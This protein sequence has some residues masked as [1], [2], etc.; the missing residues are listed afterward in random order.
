MHIVRISLLSFYKTELPFTP[1]YFHIAPFH[2]VWTVRF[3][4]LDINANGYML[5]NTWETSESHDWWFFSLAAGTCASRTSC[6]SSAIPSSASSLCVL[7]LFQVLHLL[8][9]PVNYAQ[10]CMRPLT[11]RN[12]IS[13]SIL[14][15]IIRSIYIHYISFTFHLARWMVWYGIALPHEWT[16]GRDLDPHGEQQF[17][18]WLAL[19]AG[20]DKGVQVWL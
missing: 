4:S 6:K 7:P 17:C 11:S 2:L 5:K 15:F 8:K 10:K 9:N 18:E 12:L 19:G 20:L 13:S 14:H 3:F 1:I 16:W